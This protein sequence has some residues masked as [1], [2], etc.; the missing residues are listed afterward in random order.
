[1][2]ADALRSIAVAAVAMAM[3][4]CHAFAPVPPTGVPG[5]L[6]TPE[7][8]A[9]GERRL[10]ATGAGVGALLG[11]NMTAGSAT[12]TWGIAE[13]VDVAI[14]PTLQHY[15]D[16]AGRID[17]YRAG[18]SLAY[19][20]DA[21]VKARPFATEHVAV[22]GGLGGAV[23]RRATFATASA[24][25]SF[26]YVNRTLVPFVD[27]YGYAGVPILSAPFVYRSSTSSDPLTLEAASA[28]GGLVSAG[29]AWPVTAR[30]DV[31]AAGAVGWVVTA[32]DSSQ[33]VGIAF[34]AGYAYE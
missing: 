9:R 31:R 4:G 22:F 23:N 17:G 33:L 18:D 26:A 29:L 15:G 6:E 12:L 14:S 3:P 24:G 34:G 25:A 13:Q 2:P 20:V 7:T 1:M 19:G 5:L 11:P 8:L 10:S 21:R 28:L 27:L 16:P 30:V 32:S